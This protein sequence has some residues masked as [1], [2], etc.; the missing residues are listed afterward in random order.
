[1]GLPLQTVY[2]FT[3]LSKLVHLAL[4]GVLPWYY[5]CLAVMA[6]TIAVLVAQA[7]L[8]PQYRS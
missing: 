3:A 1:M 5:L 2:P 8:C 6:V 7:V 4:D